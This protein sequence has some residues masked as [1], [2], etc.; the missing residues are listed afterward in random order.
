MGKNRS[1]IGL[2]CGISMRSSSAGEGDIRTALTET[3]ASSSRGWRSGKVRPGTIIIKI[4]SGMPK[5]LNRSGL[6][7]SERKIS[8][9]HVHVTDKD[10]SR[11]SRATWSFARHFTVCCPRV[12]YL[13]PGA[14]PRFRALALIL[15]L[16]F[17][18]NSSLESMCDSPSKRHDR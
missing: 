11:Q 8:A 17:Y 10:L 6:A 1:T 15:P 2:T 18:P 5:G 13:G 16:Y 14:A 12:L 7:L 9:S 3:E 4:G